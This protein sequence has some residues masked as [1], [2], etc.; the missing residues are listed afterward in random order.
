[1]IERGVNQQVILASPTTLI[2]LLRAVAYGWRQ[3]SLARHVQQ[4]RDLGKELH[5]RIGSLVGHFENVG[6]ALHRAVES[7]NKLLGSLENRVLVSTRKFAALGAP[8]AE[9]IP[10]LS[11][12]ETTT[13]QL[14]PEWSQQATIFDEPVAED[15]AEPKVPDGSADRR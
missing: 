12:I 10:E 3:E 7:Y 11:P 5:E 4:I 6:G 14:S 15:P 13:R 2:A 1:L 9:E 8:I